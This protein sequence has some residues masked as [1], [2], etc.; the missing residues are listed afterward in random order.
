MK[1]YL[2]FPVLALVLTSC[3]V[4][5]YSTQSGKEDVAYISF[6]DDKSQEIIVK[7]DD[8]EYTVQT[9]KQKAYKSDRNIKKMA[10]N[11]IKITPGEHQVKV[12]S[13]GNQVLNKKV[14]LSTAETKIIE[15]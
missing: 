4:G 5:I 15:L 8:T 1:K 7:I 10:L 13:N 11:S 3:G 14:F 12:I 6:I 2:I 9:V